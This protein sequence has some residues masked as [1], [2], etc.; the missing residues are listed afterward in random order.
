MTGIQDEM[1]VGT[2]N[3]PLNETLTVTVLETTTVRG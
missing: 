2:L 1:P 3:E